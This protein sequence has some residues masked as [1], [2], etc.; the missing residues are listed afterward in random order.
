M[1]IHGIALEGRKVFTLHD[2]SKPEQIDTILGRIEAGQSVAYASEAGMP[3]IA[4][5]GFELV[6]AA[7]QR[8]LFVTSAPGPTAVT[9]ALALGGL[10]TDAFHFAGF[11]PSARGQRVSA[12]EKL[13]DTEA[14][15]V[16][17]E[18]PKRVAAML[19]D[20]EVAL[21]ADRQ[22]RICRELTKKF[23]DVRAGTISELRRSI[24]SDPPR[25]E[26]VVLIDRGVRAVASEADIEQALRTALLTMKTKDAAAFVAKATQAAKRD[27]YQIALRLKQ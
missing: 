7:Q 22:A 21:S 25:G 14:T 11:L 15:L 23:E 18:S 10:A 2:H 26:I 4:D 9:T 17:Y 3:L 13:K 1:D 8:D 24:D 19:A 5:P 12:L 20:A 6:R 16:F 27:V